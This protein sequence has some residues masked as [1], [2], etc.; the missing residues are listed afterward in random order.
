[1]S[2]VHHLENLIVVDTILEVFGN[3]L[4][5]IKVNDSILV[6]VEKSEYSLETVFGS[7]L[8]NLSGSDIDKLVKSDGLA[9]LLEAIDDSQNIGA[10]SVNT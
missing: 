9:F 8:T 2:A 5:F 10:S 6:L 3:S 7:A 4:E 1:M